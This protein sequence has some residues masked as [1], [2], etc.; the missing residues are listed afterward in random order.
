MKKSEMN[1]DQINKRRLIMNRLLDAGWSDQST[2]DWF[3]KDLWAEH[4]ITMQYLGAHMLLEFEFLFE[5]YSI[6][7]IISDNLTKKE[8][9]FALFPSKKQ[10]EKILDE[11]ISVQDRISPSN[12]REYINKMLLICPKMYA[13]LGPDEKDMIKLERNLDF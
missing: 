5:D 13:V 8:L 11:F 10:M 6:N 9:V 12:F 4:E 7:Y 1:S 3:E 2:D